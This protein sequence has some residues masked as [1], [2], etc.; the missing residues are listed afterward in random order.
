MR[1][2][3]ARFSEM[4]GRKCHHPISLKAHS[5]SS[6]SHSQ[7]LRTSLT[8]PSTNSPLTRHIHRTLGGATPLSCAKKVLRNTVRPPLPHI[9]P[10]LTRVTAL[11][12]FQSK[13]APQMLRNYLFNG[14]RRLSAEALFFIIPFGAGQFLFIHPSHL[15]HAFETY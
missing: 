13:A 2:S 1:P 7:S 4:P 12:P 14:Y 10:R 5:P 15:T 9:H 3:I 6:S 11:S 8:S